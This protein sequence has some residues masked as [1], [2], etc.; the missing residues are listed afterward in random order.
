MIN[1]KFYIPE[2]E[3]IPTKLRLIVKKDEGKDIQIY[4]ERLEE[5][6]GY[7]F[8]LYDITSEEET[9]C[10]VKEIGQMMCDQSYDHGQ[11]WRVENIEKLSCTINNLFQKAEYNI[12]FRIRDSY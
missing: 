10:I 3:S 5:S 8:E 12:L 7:N 1:I 11:E 2:C 9:E 4:Y 6:F